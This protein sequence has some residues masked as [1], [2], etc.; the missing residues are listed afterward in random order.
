[1]GPEGMPDT[2]MSWSTDRRPQI[3]P[4]YAHSNE[5]YKPIKNLKKKLTNTKP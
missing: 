1:M 3:K 4:H 2:E 5:T